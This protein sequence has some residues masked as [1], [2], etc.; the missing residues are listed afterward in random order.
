MKRKT[1]DDYKAG[2]PQIPTNTCPYIDF[3]KEI[4]KEAQDETKNYFINEKLGLLD[5]ILEYIRESND[6]LRQSGEYWYRA[7][8]N[9]K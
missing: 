9:K 8:L 1:I 5:S 4:I 7:F 3:A 2:A 6:S